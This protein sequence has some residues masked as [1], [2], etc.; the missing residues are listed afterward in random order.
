MCQRA[1]VQ[2]SG[3]GWM[4]VACDLLCGMNAGS[5]MLNITCHV[6]GLCV[7]EVWM[8][9]VC[10][11]WSYS[12]RK[13]IK[14]TGWQMFHESVEITP[15]HLPRLSPF[16]FTAEFD[17]RFSFQTGPFL[18]GWPLTW[19]AP[20]AVC[21]LNKHTSCQRKKNLLLDNTTA[22]EYW[23]KCAAHLGVGVVGVPRGPERLLPSYIPH[24]EVGVLHHDFLHVAPDG[25]RCVDHLIHQTWQKQNH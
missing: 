5:P 7:K 22:R 9:E 3:H 13:R 10:C 15:T 21:A 4:D 17:P 2:P 23:L 18:K 20:A 25:G 12:K 16:S 11:L 6:L 8:S 14:R 24:Q 19:A 1:G